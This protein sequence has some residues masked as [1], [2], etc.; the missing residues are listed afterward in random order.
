MKK[1][2]LDIVRDKRESFLNYSKQEKISKYMK[3]INAS[4][5]IDFNKKYKYS[6]HL[7]CKEGYSQHA[8]AL[9]NL[10]SIK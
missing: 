1:K 8:I 4:Y 5:A 6:G 9:L 3:Y 10:I 7:A 2:L